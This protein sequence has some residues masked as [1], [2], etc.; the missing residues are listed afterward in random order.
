MY[1]GILWNWFMSCG[2]PIKMNK[3]HNNIIYFDG[4]T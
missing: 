2:R 3:Y 4:D 1:L